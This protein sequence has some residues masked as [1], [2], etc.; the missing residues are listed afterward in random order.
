MNIFLPELVHANTAAGWARKMP[1]A[2]C[3]TWAWDNLQAQ[4][5]GHHAIDR[6]KERGVE[7]GSTQRSSLSGWER[8]IVN[9][10]NIGTVIQRQHWG[11]SWEM[12]WSTYGLSRAHRYHL[13]LSW[14]ELNCDTWWCCEHTSELWWIQASRRSR[15]QLQHLITKPMG[16]F[17][18]A[19]LIWSF[20]FDLLSVHWE[21]KTPLRRLVPL[22]LSQLK[23]STE[24]EYLWV[25]VQI[26]KCLWF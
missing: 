21:M 17:T 15:I 2:S 16:H 4:S 14:T 20:Q 7:T 26:R 23:Y 12:G 1:L 6:Q 3:G 13:E 8:A 19:S 9:Q 24:T 5:Q 25:W 22:R 11:N 10:I 18:T